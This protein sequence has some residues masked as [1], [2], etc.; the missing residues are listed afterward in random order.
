M[1]TSH[2]QVPS[3][4]TLA[5][6]CVS[7][8]NTGHAQE[9]NLPGVT[10]PTRHFVVL[11]TLD[12]MRSSAKQIA[13]ACSYQGHTS[14]P[15]RHIHSRCASHTSH[16][17]AVYRHDIVQARCKALCRSKQRPTA[18]PGNSSGVRKSHR[19]GTEPVSSYHGTPLSARASSQAP[20]SP[21]HH[22]LSVAQAPPVR[23][24]HAQSWFK[25]PMQQHPKARGQPAATMAHH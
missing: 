16:T 4:N 12:G 21:K 6:F 13:P 15:P 24:C 19:E 23:T 11:S 10:K 5:R 9:V 2:T 3:C 14:R 1:L 18:A 20:R 8:R 17:H 22:N 7:Q 25:L